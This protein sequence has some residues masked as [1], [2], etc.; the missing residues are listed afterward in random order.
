MGGGVS[1]CNILEIKCPNNYNIID[2]V[3]IL[4]LYNNVNLYRNI[5]NSELQQV[6][7][8]YINRKKLILINNF[9]QWKMERNTL[10]IQKFKLLLTTQF[11]YLEKNLVHEYY[12]LKDQRKKYLDLKNIVF[13]NQ[14][15]KLE[16]LTDKQKK[17]RFMKS[18]SYANNTI[19]FW[20]F[21]NI[22]KNNVDD[23]NKI[24][25]TSDTEYPILKD[26]QYR[27]PTSINSN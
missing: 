10:Q 4:K 12:K 15:A 3:N 26:D 13:K 14:I 16:N 1:Q 23:I 6:A 18:V 17:D 5:E 27:K 19:D 20:L 8:M 21:F 24:V 9:E 22:M 2:F 7:N 11:K 25:W